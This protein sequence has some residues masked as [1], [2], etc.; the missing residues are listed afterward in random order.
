ML[1]NSELKEKFNKDGYLIV[2]KV[3]DEELN[4]SYLES[5]SDV[6]KQGGFNHVYT[7]HTHTYEP[8]KY[9]HNGLLEESIQNPHAYPWSQSV[10]D[11][12]INILCHKN[13]TDSLK[14]VIDSNE[15]SAIW[16]SMYFDKSTGT[17]PHQDSYYLD[18]DPFGGVVGIWFALEDITM[19]A[20]L[21]YVIP[22]SHKDGILFKESQC[23]GRYEDHDKFTQTMVD[24]EKKNKDKVT[25][26]LVNKGDIVIWNS[27]LVHGAFNSSSSTKSRKSLTAHYFPQGSNLKF[28]DTIP[29]LTCP[30]GHNVPIMGYLSNNQVFKSKVK[31]M[32]N[33]ALQKIKNL[34]PDMDMR[35]NS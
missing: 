22:G 29:S 17:L 16:Q 18:T 20:G 24:Y 34:G 25:P 5:I 13:V 6:I 7:Q 32:V 27:T 8:L 28:F 2:K 14:N 21:F 11:A 1:N 26:M 4:S 33:V 30:P 9:N 23:G 35:R 15:R 19:E 3:V 31:M 12:V 10:R